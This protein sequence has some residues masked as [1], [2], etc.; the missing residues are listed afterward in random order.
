MGSFPEKSDEELARV[1]IDTDQVDTGAQLVAGVTLPLDPGESLRI[2]RKID[3]HIMPLMCIL[4]WIQF[5]DKVTLGSSAIL[6]I[7]YELE[8]E[9]QKC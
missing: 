8:L 3:K 5:M 2:R 7:L 6:G 1:S 4:Y 9:F